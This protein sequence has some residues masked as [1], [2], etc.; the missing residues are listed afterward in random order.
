MGKKAAYGKEKMDEIR[1]RVEEIR[2]LKGFSRN[3]MARAMGL[4]ST[5]NFCVALNGG[6]NFSSDMLYRMH[7]E[8]GVNKDWLIDGVG[9]MFSAPPAENL[10]QSFDS[11]F[12]INGNNSSNVTQQVNKDGKS[13]Q[14]IN[15]YLMEQIKAKDEEIARLNNRLDKLIEIINKN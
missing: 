2:V 1:K 8:L 4:G 5:S 15:Q 10:M 14:A 3:G 12:N 11:A 9:E 7:K 13:L 6:A